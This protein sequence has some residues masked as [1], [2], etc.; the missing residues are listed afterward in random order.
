MSRPLP[1]GMITRKR[2]GNILGL[3]YRVNFLH[4]KLS[5]LVNIH[6]KKKPA[7]FS[8][9]STISR[10]RNF[11]PIMGRLFLFWCAG[12]ENHLFPSD[13]LTHI[14]LLVLTCAA[15]F[16][17]TTTF[18]HTAYISGNSHLDLQVQVCADIW[19]FL[20]RGVNNA[21]SVRCIFTAKANI[22]SLGLLAPFN[23]AMHDTLKQETQA[24]IHRVLPAH[25]LLHIPAGICIDSA[26]HDSDFP[27]AAQARLHDDTQIH[28]TF[29][30]TC[31]PH[32]VRSTEV[33]N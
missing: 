31:G 26:A 5:L 9:E 14:P 11:M 25:H 10:T 28:A 24:L 29:Q 16:Q 2:I 19:T 3:L 18:L 33:W 21:A 13:P 12:P 6:E 15:P 27:S 23:H 20:L 7:S 17:T 22:L 1:I 30:E 4:I 8:P 32:S